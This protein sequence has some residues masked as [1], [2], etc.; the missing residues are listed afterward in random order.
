[1][2]PK[3]KKST[4]RTN[5]YGKPSK[6][7]AAQLREARKQR[8][9]TNLRTPKETQSTSPQLDTPFTPQPSTSRQV[10]PSSHTNSTTSDAANTHSVS[11]E[12]KISLQ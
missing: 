8:N 6:K 7:R 1:M 9:Q 4:S 2:K 5:S 10:E 3:L 12:T 11:F